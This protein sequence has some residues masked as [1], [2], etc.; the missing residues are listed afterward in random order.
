MV[1]KWTCNIAN[2]ESDIIIISKRF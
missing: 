2:M 1:M